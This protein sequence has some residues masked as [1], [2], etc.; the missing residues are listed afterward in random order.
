[1]KLVVRMVAWMVGELVALKVE[2][3]DVRK[4]ASKVCW[5]VVSM[6]VELVA[7]MV[8]MKAESLVVSMEYVMV[9]QMAV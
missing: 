7:I 5:M 6:D 4:A 8:V 1:M 2:R 3:K 9:V